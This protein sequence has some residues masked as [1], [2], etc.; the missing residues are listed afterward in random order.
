[1]LVYLS[2]PVA[3]GYF[4]NIG[5]WERKQK[6]P[7]WVILRLPTTLSRIITPSDTSKQALV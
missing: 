6:S 5:T 3:S 7:L 4:D 1:M 2:A